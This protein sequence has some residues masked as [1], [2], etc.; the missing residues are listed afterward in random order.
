MNQM[1][2]FAL[3]F[4]IGTIPAGFVMFRVSVRVLARR[5][6]LLDNEEVQQAVE[7]RRAA[8]ESGRD[9]EVRPDAGPAA[10]I[11]NLFQLRRRK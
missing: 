7:K 2:W 8:M 6:K 1:A 11:G 5:A 10:K 4:G 3:G 9:E